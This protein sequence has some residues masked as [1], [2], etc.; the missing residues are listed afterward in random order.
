MEKLL[1]QAWAQQF[2]DWWLIT[3]ENLQEVPWWQFNEWLSRFVFYYP[4]LMAYVWMLGGM[5]YYVRWER[6]RGN[7]LS[8]LPELSEYPSVSILIPCYNEGENVRETIEYLLHQQ[9]PHVEIIAINDG[10]KDNTLDI[11]HELADQHP[12]IRVVNLASNQGKAV[13]LR[14]AA[15]LANSEILIG[16]DGDALLAPNATAWIVRHFLEDP[17]V[18]AVTGNPRIRN[19]STLLGKI[20]VGEFSAIVGMIKRAQRSYGHV[21]TISGVIAGFRKT[22]LHDVGYWS[23]DMV[24]EDIDIS[25]K[26]QLAGWAIRFEP[27]ALCWVLMPETLNGLWKQRSRW[28]Q[29]GVEVL[30]RYFRPLFRWRSRGM[31][32]LYLECCI[33]LTWA[34]LVVA[35]LAQVP[36]EWFSSEP[37]E[38]LEDLSPHWTSMLLCVTCLIQFAVSLTIDSSYERK[39]GGSAQH[40]YWMIWYPII[41]WLINVGTTINGCIMALRKKRGQRAVWVT[42]DRG[43]RQK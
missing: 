2:I 34:F 10:S 35:M 18:G 23:P 29:G 5:I 9:Y 39:S 19:R 22:A 37:Q 20:Q 24:T 6:N 17:H 21:F 26:L 11:L 41:Y 38:A 32:P 27:N 14:T 43:L 7:V 36:F 13:G 3:Q 31:W 16:I 28:A 1:D 15:L 30:L 4:L 33:S 12:Q 25:W 42:L 8:D 40:Y